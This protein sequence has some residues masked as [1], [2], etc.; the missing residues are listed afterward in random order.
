MHSQWTIREYKDKEMDDVRGEEYLRVSNFSSLF[1]AKDVAHHHILQPWNLQ[2]KNRTQN[3][4][5]H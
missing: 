5:A 3:P 1:L 4:F 2:C